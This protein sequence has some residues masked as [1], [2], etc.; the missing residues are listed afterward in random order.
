MARLHTSHVFFFFFLIPMM[1]VLRKLY[2]LRG[3][4]HTEPTS[5]VVVLLWLQIQ[6]ERSANQSLTL[7]LTALSSISF[8]VSC[9]SSTWTTTHPEHLHCNVFSTTKR[10][11]RCP[12][13]FS[14]L[15]GCP[16][17][18]K[19]QLNHFKRSVTEFQPWRDFV[20]E[21]W[22]ERTLQCINVQ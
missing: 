9:R 16:S 11:A 19:R 20:R 1:H 22:C 7:V 15:I 21:V 12:P 18:R 4:V 3:C 14:T 13:E 6:T 10:F 2:R 5:V 17:A 8:T